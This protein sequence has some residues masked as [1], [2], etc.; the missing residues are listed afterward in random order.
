MYHGG[1]KQKRGSASVSA[2]GVILRSES[3]M[4]SRSC[5]RLKATSSRTAKAGRRSRGIILMVVYRLRVLSAASRY[6]YTTSVL[7]VCVCVCVP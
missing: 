6:I 1:E 4:S 5:S 7:A 2:I 3:F